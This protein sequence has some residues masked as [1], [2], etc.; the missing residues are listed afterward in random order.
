MT[1]EHLTPQ[2]QKERKGLSTD[3]QFLKARGCKPFFRGSTLKFSDGAL[4]CNY[5]RDEANRVVAAAAPAAR[6][7]SPPRAR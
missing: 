7:A 4:I 2:Q 5:A 3:F 1:S 6:A